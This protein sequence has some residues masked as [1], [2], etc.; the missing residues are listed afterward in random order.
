MTTHT[1]RLLAW[2]EHADEHARR[3]GLAWYTRCLRDV[4]DAVGRTPHL[5]HVGAF[6]ALSPRVTYRQN[7][8]MFRDLV[9]GRDVRG[10]TA[11]VREAR[12][13]LTERRLPRG[14]KTSA[15][16]RCIM[17]DERAVCLDSWA[18]RALGM[19]DQPSHLEFERAVLAYQETADVLGM[20]PSALQATVWVAIRGKAW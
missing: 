18:L 20:V 19:G 12:A 17:G 3:E 1:H 6:A 4:R 9:E 15:F 8:R 16:A 14:R 5:G 2:Y 13:C 11:S 7:V 10:L